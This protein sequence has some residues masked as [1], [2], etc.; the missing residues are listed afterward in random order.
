MHSPSE[1]RIPSQRP[2]EFVVQQR[3]VR[4]HAHQLQTRIRVEHSRDDF[5]KQLNTQNHPVAARRL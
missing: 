1:S 4:V 3:R 2:R 5:R